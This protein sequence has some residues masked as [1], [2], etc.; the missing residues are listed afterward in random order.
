MLTLFLF[1]TEG[2]AARF[3]ELRADACTAIIGVGMAEAGASA[4]EAIARYKPQRVVLAGIAGAC[5]E[6]VGVG[7][8]VA[9]VSDMVVALPEAFRVE[10]C[11]SEC[12]GLRSAVTY[13]VNRTGESLPFCG[14]GEALLPA[15]EQME[16]AAVAAV[17][18]R[19]GVEYLHLRSISNRVTDSRSE[20]RIGQ[21]IDALTEQLLAICDEKA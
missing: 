10:Y 2:E 9:V 3:K 12:D 20:W 17:C 15:V 8:C 16:G 21:A 4:A 18:R 14:G 11:G 13:T 5:D 7:E 1:P 6:R 19:A